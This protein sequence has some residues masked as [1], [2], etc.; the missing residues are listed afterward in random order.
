MNAHEQQG[1][2]SARTTGDFGGKR[3]LVNGRR[4]RRTANG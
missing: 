1:W 4:R 3:V 2:A